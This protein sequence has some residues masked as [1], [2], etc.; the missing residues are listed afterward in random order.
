MAPG[1]GRSF[2]GDWP[3]ADIAQHSSYPSALMNTQ[4][5]PGLHRES[6]MN[7]ISKRKLVQALRASQCR[8]VK[9]RGLHEKW[10]CPCDEHHTTAVPRHRE[11]T[12]G[13][14]R[15]IIDDLKCLPKGWL[16]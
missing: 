13:V 16:Q 10:I 8:M 4:S 3:D 14:V 7:P 11:V 2:T 1:H 6:F 15:N 5:K 9:K 12:A